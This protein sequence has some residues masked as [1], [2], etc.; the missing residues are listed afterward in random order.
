MHKLIVFFIVLGDMDA[1]R[2]LHQL[3]S[4]TLQGSHNV[5]AHHGIGG[6]IRRQIS[7]PIAQ[8]VRA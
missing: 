7:Q 8:G 3:D 2:T 4:G 1:L 6:I 5:P